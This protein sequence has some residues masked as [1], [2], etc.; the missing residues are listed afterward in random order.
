MIQCRSRGNR[1]ATELFAEHGVDGAG[2]GP[3]RFAMI[4]G[5]VVGVGDRDIGFR[6]DP[7]IQRTEAFHR[8]RI[9]LIGE[10]QGEGDVAN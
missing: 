9:G 5:A 6:L 7:Q 10:L 8:E 2:P 3:A 1:C 4:L